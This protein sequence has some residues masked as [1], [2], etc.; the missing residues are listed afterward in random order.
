MPDPFD[1]LAAT[2]AALEAIFKL[3]YVYCEVKPPKTRPKELAIWEAEMK[4]VRKWA[5]QIHD[6]RIE[7]NIRKLK[8]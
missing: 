7:L 3:V 5:V 1:T 4:E 6:R 2:D 8:T